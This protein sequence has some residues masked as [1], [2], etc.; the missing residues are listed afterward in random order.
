MR[1]MQSSVPK[2][3]TG[4]CLLTVGT[5]VKNVMEG[6]GTEGREGEDQ[7]RFFMWMCRFPQI[8]WGRS[9]PIPCLCFCCCVVHMYISPR[10]FM[11]KLYI[12]TWTWQHEFCKYVYLYNS[13]GDKKAAT[14][15]QW[16]PFYKP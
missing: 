10:P 8:Y 14:G 15:T 4:K 7:A 6:R 1:G 16:S 3:N 11:Y 2:R 12:V 9:R 13:H 5:D